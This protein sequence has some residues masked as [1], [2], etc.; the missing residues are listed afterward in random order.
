MATMTP[1]DAVE[2]AQA[3]AEVARQAADAAQASA[4]MDAAAY[5]QLT[6]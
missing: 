2:R 6:A 1:Q 3:A 4:L 5:T